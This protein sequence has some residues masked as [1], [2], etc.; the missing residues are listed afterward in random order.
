MN[1]IE[2]RR[3]ARLLRLE[4]SQREHRE[5]LS[6]AASLG[7]TVALAERRGEV[8]VQAKGRVRIWSRDGLRSLYESG[9][10]DG[11]QYEAGLS[12]R[13]CLEAVQSLPGGLLGDAVDNGAPVDHGHLQAL[14]ACR[15]TIME[16]LARTV[17]EATTLRVVAGEGRAIRGLSGGGADYALNV[18]ALGVILERIAERF[19]L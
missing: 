17:R 4:A 14:R 12:Y 2:H 1:R 7:Q 9:A 5:G 11:E 18:K 19:G 10:L 15:L 3:R 16:G 13:K 8:V 6:L